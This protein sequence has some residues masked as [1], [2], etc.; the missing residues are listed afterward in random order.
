MLMKISDSLS[1]YSSKCANLFVKKKNQGDLYH[2][3]WSYKDTKELI[4]LET[5][6]F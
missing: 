4:K 3:F 6:C 2:I 1:M 5:L